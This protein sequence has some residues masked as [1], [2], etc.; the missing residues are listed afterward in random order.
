[1]S[2]IPSPATFTFTQAPHVITVPN[3]VQVGSNQWKFSNWEDGTTNPTRAINVQSNLSLSATYIEVP[4]YTISLT[5]DKATA[6]VG[7]VLTLTAT[8]LNN[9]VP[10]DGQTVNLY[11][12]GAVFGSMTGKGSGQYTLQATAN[13]AG[14]LNLQ[15]QALGASSNT[16]QVT[17]T[18]PPHTLTVSSGG[19]GTTTPSGANTYSYGSIVSVS[20]IADTGYMLSNWT[21]DGADV[22]SANPYPVTMTSDHQL[23]ANFVVIPPNTWNLNISATAGGTTNPSG[24]IIVAQGQGQLVQETPDSGYNFSKWVFDGLDIGT[25][26]VANIPAQ[27]TG[28]SHT[29]QA[30]FVSTVVP[31][32]NVWPVLL[33]LAAG[34]AMVLAG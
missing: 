26:T 27:Q 5:C 22:G 6:Q 16:V 28:T 15:A 18:Q 20:A 3:V 7:D 24:N 11:V 9:G 10:D 25:N 14:I 31:R 23:T 19:N 8:L 17:I 21:L 33:L 4:L 12:N 2:T 13:N 1:M 29:L 30:Q 34:A 32:P